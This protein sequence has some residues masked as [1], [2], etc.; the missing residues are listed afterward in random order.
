MIYYIDTSVL[1]ENIP[2]VKFIKTTSG[3][4]PAPFM[5]YTCD[6]ILQSLQ[7]QQQCRWIGGYEANP[8]GIKEVN[9]LATSVCESMFIAIYT[10]QKIQLNMRETGAASGSIETW[11][12]KGVKFY[13]C[14][15][16]KPWSTDTHCSLI[17]QKKWTSLS[18]TFLPKT[19]LKLG[20]QAKEILL[21]YWVLVRWRRNLKTVFNSANFF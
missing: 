11:K 5:L 7:T 15:R 13:S 19:I 16:N 3:T 8:S 17:G 4:R 6:V 12:K 21:F 18:L 14:L 10:T 9:S 2:L 20:F 1:L